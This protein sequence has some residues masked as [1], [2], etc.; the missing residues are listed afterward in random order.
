MRIVRVS[1]HRPGDDPFAQVFDA[2]GCTVEYVSDPSALTRILAQHGWHAVVADLASGQAPDAAAVLAQLAEQETP[3]PTLIGHPLAREAEAIRLF[4]RG[5]RD[6]VAFEHPDRLGPALAREHRLENR[7]ESL[8]R[9]GQR[10]RWLLSNVN[11]AVI[12]DDREGR[13]VFANDR[14]LS[15]FAFDSEDVGRLR[16]EDYVAPEYQ[17]TLR[18]RHDRRIAGD[19]CAQR[20][21]FEG[22]TRDGRRIWL[23]ARVDVVIEGG[24][25][26][27]TQSTIVDI[28]DRRQWERTQHALREIA[29]AALDATDLAD[30]YGRIH[31]IIDGLLPAPNFYVAMYDADNDMVSFP[32]FLDENDEAPPPQKLGDSTL[33]ATVVRSGRSVLLSASPTD[34]GGR[35]E[36]IAGTPPAEWLG[37]PLTIDER[38]IGAI[39]VQ[40]YTGGAHYSQRHRELL[41]FVSTHIAAAIRRTQAQSRLR[42][43][44]EMLR[45]IFE[46][47]P[48]MIGLLSVPEG[49]IIA[50]NSEAVRRYG[51]TAEDMIGRTSEDLDMWAVPGDRERYLGLLREHGTVRDFETVIRTRQGTHFPAIYNG[52]LVT[53]G[54]QPYSLNIME[55][56]SERKRA[57]AMLVSERNFSNALIENAG[58][59]IVV[60]DHEGRIRRFNRC[61]ETVTGFTLDEVKGRCLW[62]VMM[63]PTL[64]V[65]ARR[66][67]FQTSLGIDDA[68]PEFREVHW[69]ARNGLLRTIQFYNSALDGPPGEGRFMVC[70]G[71]DVTERL[72]MERQLRNSE[73]R[74]RRAQSIAK[75]GNWEYDLSEDRLWWSD[76]VFSLVGADPAY[77]TPRFDDFLSR[78][79]EDEGRRFQHFYR[80]AL[81]QHTAFQVIHRLIRPDGRTVYLEQR[82]E[83][84]YDEDDS[85]LL[86][87]GTT[88]DV[89][90]RVLAEQSLK[91]SLIEKET[92][93]REIHHRV[94]NNLQIIASLLYFEAKKLRD[95][96]ALDAFK[97][98]NDRLRAMT[99]VHERLYASQVGSVEFGDYLD[100]LIGELQHSWGREMAARI[101]IETETERD[102][103]L[104]LDTVLPLG[105]TVVE[106]LTNAF[107]Y[108]FP[109]RDQG[110]V[111]VAVERDHADLCICIQDDGIGLPPGMD[112]KEQGGFGWKLTLALVRQLDGVID[113]DGSHGLRITIR[114]PLVERIGNT[115]SEP[116]ST[117]IPLTGDTMGGDQRST[118]QSL[119][120]RATGAQHGA[121]GG[122]TETVGATPVRTS[123][124]T[125]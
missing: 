13:V 117:G 83:T 17:V 26:V 85:P 54:D 65:D 44:E 106:L 22:L 66:T 81:E 121:D 68:R 48:N 123:G 103:V 2:S 111:K 96:A 51:G 62:D 73:V 49:R 57:E 74:L 11:D 122:T 10:M 32:Y 21:Q 80:Q 108:A 64:S 25:I 119:G 19:D 116:V 61:A 67:A 82:C 40:S 23:D 120:G 36:T 50:A 98:I 56:I 77:G 97:G 91:A 38:V 24:E 63:S 27:G 70:I 76:E 114:I 124:A 100:A 94:K 105:L 31:C 53:I 95:P 72:Q 1:D 92:L 15:M 8:I 12:V 87:R 86:S 6:I 33:T 58:T 78:L 107:K 93:L 5:A 125:G 69:I 4:E 113:Y 43:S 16:L 79:P 29:G 71:I 55:D 75:L 7:I 18:H 118:M 115:N 104:P 20:F 37:V 52:A 41:E 84:E 90:E 109:N 28:T 35:V 99:L 42:E 89:T 14:F 110:R 102:L 9:R 34:G 47:S 88:Q 30:L 45:A 112:P 39:A 59:L 60:L 3:L 101:T 46:Q